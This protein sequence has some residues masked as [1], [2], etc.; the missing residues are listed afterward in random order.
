M[1]S[2]LMKL[3]KEN[4]VFTKKE[5]ILRNIL[6]SERI[7]SHFALE[8]FRENDDDRKW[9]HFT[10][11]FV[12]QSAEKTGILSHTFLAKIRESNGFTK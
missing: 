5:L 2:L 12:K 11:Y 4:D 3:K 9:F 8:E 10:K 6:S 7:C 1:K